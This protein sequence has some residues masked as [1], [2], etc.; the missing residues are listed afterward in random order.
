MSSVNEELIAKGLLKADKGDLKRFES[1]D[2]IRNV[3]EDLRKER[4]GIWEESDS[5]E[6]ETEEY[7]FVLIKSFDFWNF[8]DCYQKIYWKFPKFE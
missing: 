4:V 7:W 8:R 6:E 2:F 5:S 1:K 3:Q